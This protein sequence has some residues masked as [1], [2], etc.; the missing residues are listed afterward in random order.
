ML[1]QRRRVD[2]RNSRG[3]EVVDVRFLN[4]ALGNENIPFPV[5]THAGLMSGKRVTIS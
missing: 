2:Q 5:R 4:L 1:Y 3:W